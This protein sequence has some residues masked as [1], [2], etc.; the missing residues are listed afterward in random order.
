LAQTA[1]AFVSDLRRDRKASMKVSPAAQLIH[2]DEFS[3]IVRPNAKKHDKHMGKIPK[4][5]ESPFGDFP[6][7]YARPKAQLGRGSSM[8][9][10]AMASMG[11]AYPSATENFQ[12]KGTGSGGMSSSITPRKQQPLA[13]PPKAGAH[14]RREIKASEFRRFYDRG[15]LPIQVQHAGTTNKVF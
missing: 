8:R 4:G 7:D 9:I 3:R 6:Q 13:P 11:V 1:F 14:A 12:T 5:L 15:D 2:Q 10:A